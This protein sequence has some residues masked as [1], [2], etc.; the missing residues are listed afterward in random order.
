MT[1]NRTRDHLEILALTACA[2]PKPSIL[3]LYNHPTIFPICAALG[4]RRLTRRCP[5]RAYPKIAGSN[6]PLLLHLF[7]GPAE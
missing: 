2:A 3:P 7:Y 4:G 5:S 6:T 1:G